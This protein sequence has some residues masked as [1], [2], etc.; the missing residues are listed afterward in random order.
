MAVLK[1]VLP[2]CVWHALRLV[3]L[4]ESGGMMEMSYLPQ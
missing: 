1:P 2:V 3:Q 4:P